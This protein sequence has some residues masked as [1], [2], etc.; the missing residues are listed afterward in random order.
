[1][2][3]DPTTHA[4][5]L[6]AVRARS[7]AQTT[8]TDGVRLRGVHLTDPANPQVTALVHAHGFTHRTSY[9][10]TRRVL[11]A[12]AE[13]SDVVAFD[14]RGHGRSGGRN[15]VG[16]REMLDVDAAVA[17]ARAAGYTRVAT[18]G[19]SL[20]AAVVLRQA[21]LG[22]HRP[23]AVVA[24]SGPARW[25]SRETM[26]MRRVH[27]ALE[28]PHG[29]AVARLLGVRL[30]G[31]WVRVPPSPVE[32]VGQIAPTPL[33][34][35]HFTADPYFSAT[36]PRALVEATGGHAQLWTE[37]GSG[38]GET[39]TD[40][41]LAGRIATWASRAAGAQAGPLDGAWPARS[42]V[43]GGAPAD[44]RAASSEVR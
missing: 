28:Q 35:V 43:D 15:T 37:P 32:V 7:V 40:A 33:L 2:R 29:R 22:E 42:T 16:D 13:H 3:P 1:V 24:V 36:H 41:A 5:Q 11:T 39:G 18:V 20:G 19:F 30:D 9:S 44:R 17:W 4:A 10:A 38:H 14:L 8:T 6:T 12:F 34:L 21:A 27:W 31:P 26:P 25:Y 23:D